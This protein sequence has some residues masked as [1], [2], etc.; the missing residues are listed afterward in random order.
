MAKCGG[1]L[2]KAVRNVRSQAELGLQQGNVFMMIGQIDKAID[3]YSHVIALNSSDADAY[4]NRG[5][6]YREKRRP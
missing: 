6:A 2:R 4:F 5:I 3:S 1:G